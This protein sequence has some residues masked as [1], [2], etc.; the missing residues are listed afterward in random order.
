MKLRIILFVSLCTALF[1]CKKDNDDS[2]YNY[3]QGSW[4]LV[5]MG[6]DANNNQLV[7]ATE[8]MTLP[9]NGSLIT[10]FNGDLTGHGAVNLTQSMNMNMKFTWSTNEREQMLMMHMEDSSVFHNR[11]KAIDSK[12]FYLLNEDMTVLGS[13]V[14]LVY[15]R[16]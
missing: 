3:L 4:R 1:S 9:E 5:Q 8:L 16:Q 12:N 15:T 11:F 7:E 13:K 6:S 2:M 10:V 14:W